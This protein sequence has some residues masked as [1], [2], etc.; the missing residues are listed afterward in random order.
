[1]ITPRGHHTAD[2]I[3]LRCQVWHRARIAGPGVNPIPAYMARVIASWWQSADE[4]GRL[5]PFGTYAQLGIVHKDFRDAYETL[6]AMAVLDPVDRI[7]LA[8]MWRV[9]TL[10]APDA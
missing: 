2:L 7:A 6:M 9:V 1:M 3:Y 10:D 8:A 4:N 5:D